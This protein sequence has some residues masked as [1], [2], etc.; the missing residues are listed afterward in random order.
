MAYGNP[1]RIP[2]YFLLDGRVHKLLG[3]HRGHDRVTAWDYEAGCVKIYSYL[4]VRRNY[5]KLF[6]T[7]QVAEMCWRSYYY[8]KNL[9]WRGELEPTFR[10]D[11]VIL[12][13]EED[14]LKVHDYFGHMIKMGGTQRHPKKLPTRTELRAMMNN[15][16]VLYVQSK[17]GT[18]VPT[19]KAEQF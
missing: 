18:F 1:V 8:L 17:D 3:C 19:F 10:T 14:V 9:M 5:G 4:D 7:R 12:W 16:T 11:R 6:R 13:S 15:D 2:R